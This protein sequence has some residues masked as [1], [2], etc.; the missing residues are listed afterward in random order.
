MLLG[1]SGCP[2][3]PRIVCP[4][5]VQRSCRACCWV[6]TRTPPYA[7][8][9]CQISGLHF[10]FPILHILLVAYMLIA[11]TLFILVYVVHMSFCLHLI[12]CQSG[13]HCKTYFLYWPNLSSFS[14]SYTWLLFY[15]IFIFAGI[16]YSCRSLPGFWWH[17]VVHVLVVT[18]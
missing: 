12:S 9:S 7:W 18:E 8:H 1:V 11:S 14:I 5:K 4:N 10:A 16:G 2:T 3:F 17:L 13:S 15:I 6:S